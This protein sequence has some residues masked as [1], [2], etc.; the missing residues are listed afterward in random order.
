MSFLNNR[1]SPA[2]LALSLA[3][4]WPALAQAQQGEPCTGDEEFPCGIRLEEVGIARVP[5]ILKFQARVS[6]AKLPVGDGEFESVYVKVTDG[7]TTWCV[8]QFKNVQ[9]R[10]SV[11]NVAIGQ[12]ISCQLEE[13]IAEKPNLKFEICLG[14]TTSCL[15]PISLSTTPY[16]ISANFATLAQKAHSANKAATASY[17]HRMTADR[18]LFLRQKL[19]TGYF[20][21]YTPAEDPGL[22]SAACNVDDADCAQGTYTDWHDGGFMQWT[23][24]RAATTQVLHLVGKVQ[25]TDTMTWL[26]KLVLG[27]KE[28]IARFAL[29]VDKTFDVYGAA[30]AHGTL[31]VVD[32]TTTQGILANAPGAAA[33]STLGHALLVVGTA[34]LEQTLEV[35]STTTLRGTLTVADAA[36]GHFTGDVMVDGDLR[37]EQGQAVVASNIRQTDAAGAELTLQS[38]GQTTVVAGPL[39]AA[40]T[41]DVAGVATAQAVSAQAITVHGTGDSATFKGDVTIEG[42]LNV[43]AV[44]SETSANDENAVHYSDPGNTTPLEL[45]GQLTALAGVRANTVGLLGAD[46]QYHEVLGTNAGEFRL[47]NSVSEVRLKNTGVAVGPRLTTPELQVGGGGAS[48]SGPVTFNSTVQWSSPPPFVTPIDDHPLQFADVT[49]TTL[50]MGTGGASLSGQGSSVVAS[51]AIQA[52]SLNSGTVAMSGSGIEVS[53]GELLLNGTSNRPVR[54]G[55]DLHV[56]G[57][58]ATS[59]LGVGSVTVD[60][61]DS[62]GTNGAVVVKAG[63]QRLAMD[64]NEIDSNGTLYLNDNNNHPVVLGNDLEV[65]DNATVHGELRLRGKIVQTA[66]PGGF[67]YH[68][69]IC[70]SSWQPVHKYNQAVL[71]CHN[72][73][74]RVC[75]YEDWYVFW[76][77][78]FAY[79]AKGTWLGGSI[80]DDHA[81]CINHDSDR[82]NMDGEC[83]KHD[84]TGSYLCCIGGY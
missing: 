40:E 50:K 46:G 12:N 61:S 62:D 60:G 53:T 69:G 19:G 57:T 81:L 59:N 25:D 32:L 14:S 17:A 27:A 26:D 80:G 33:A 39:E 74:A 9:V 51:G 36:L 22:Y 29:V 73:H 30:T 82:E 7:N 71:S 24:V 75:T 11:L 44:A 58:L 2:L 76:D 1:F 83:N 64:G 28:T 66:C 84:H 78:G 63:G 10:D 5:T 45:G 77:P 15:K 31:S 68:A 48:F 8:E 16:A 47:H 49:I 4:V 41:L 18:D 54:T 67:S 65:G 56:D 72:Q 43:K 70:V 52:A 38:A 13:I 20:D 37:V 3:W 42:T 35:E 55:G 34:H 21:F 79:P 23:P 6:Q